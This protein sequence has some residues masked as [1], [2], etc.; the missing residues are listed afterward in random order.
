VRYGF[1]WTPGIVLFGLVVILPLVP[2]FALIAVVLLAIA[3]LVALVALAG[4][5]IAAPY[6]IGR[7]VHRRL[8]ERHMSAEAAGP[9]PLPA[10]QEVVA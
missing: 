1:E 5:I 6:L 2:S 3:A 10:A 8:E 9:R 7:A 4:A